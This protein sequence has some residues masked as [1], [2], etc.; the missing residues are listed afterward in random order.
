MSTSSFLP[1]S[2]ATYVQ[3]ETESVSVSLNERKQ[4]TKT[5]GEKEKKGKEIKVKRKGGGERRANDGGSK[6]WS[7]RSDRSTSLARHTRVDVCSGRGDK[8]KP[9]Q[10][11]T[12]A[13]K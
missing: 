6:Q 11:Q 7:G 10:T 12:H 9:E 8:R 4:K 13:N 2:E 3:P 5:R 1:S